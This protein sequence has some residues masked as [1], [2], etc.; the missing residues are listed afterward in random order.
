MKRVRWLLA[1]AVALS[2]AAWAEPGYLYDAPYGGA[3]YYY[4]PYP[5]YY[6]WGAPGGVY[7]PSEG[8][9]GGDAVIP[10]GRLI[11]LVDPVS[12]EVYVD[13]HRLNQRDDLSYQVGLLVGRHA[14]EVRAQGYRPYNQDVNLQPGRRMVITVRLKR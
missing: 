13:G 10:A 6:P 12:A 3:P 14:V 7:G 11:L 8:D 5:Y 9:F 1:A 2:S 4:A